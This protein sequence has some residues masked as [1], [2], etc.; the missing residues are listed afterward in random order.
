[1]ALAFDPEEPFQVAAIDLG[2]TK[3]AGALVTYAHHGAQPEIG[4]S[5]STPTA[6]KRGGSAVLADMVGIARQL[7][8]HAEHPVAGIGCDAAG[9]INPKDGSVLYANGIMPG[10]MGQPIA[11]RMTQVFDLPATAMGDV[12]AH[13][14]GESRWGAA[15]GRQSALMVAIGTGLGGGYILDGKVVRGFHGAAGHIGHTIHPAAAGITCACGADSHVESVTS[16]TAISAIYQGRAF[17]DDLDP[18]LMGD[19]VSARAYEGEQAAID[20]LANAGAALGRAIGSWCNILDPECVILSGTVVKAGPIWRNALEEAFATQALEPLATT[21]ILDG[22]LAGAA[23][24]IG[25]AE[26]L[27]DTLFKY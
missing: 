13:A 7:I 1:M 10:W 2:G 21:P 26:N 4:W 19:T 17:G 25:A 12:H 5:T 3:I 15:R 27:C 16:G 18:A 24:L 8:E 6:P 14:L 9:C 20:V 23:P 22:T 11:E